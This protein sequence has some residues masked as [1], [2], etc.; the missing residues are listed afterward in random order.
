VP[1]E[2]NRRPARGMTVAPPQDIKAQPATS[3]DTSPP[4]PS[5][6]EANPGETWIAESCGRDAPVMASLLAGVEDGPSSPSPEK[7]GSWDPEELVCV[8]CSQELKNEG[9]PAIATSV[10]LR[11]VLYSLSLLGTG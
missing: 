1:S 2:A 7:E 3:P 9:P 8:V 5:N 6:R 4:P 10:L 11:W